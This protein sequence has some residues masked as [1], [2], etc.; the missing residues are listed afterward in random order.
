MS[1]IQKPGFSS[2][3]ENL[4]SISTEEKSLSIPAVEKPLSISAAEKPLSIPAVE[5]PLS[6]PAAEKP[7]SILA[8]EKP[9]SIST[10]AIFSSVPT[11]VYCRVSTLHPHQQDSL[12]NQIRHYQEFM[13]KTQNYILTEIYYDF[14]ISGY[15][16]T[17]PGFC[18]MLEDARKGCF[19]QIITKSITRF[20]RNTDTVLK[21]TRQLKELG[22]DIYF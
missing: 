14:G 8:A 9:L 11:A 2:P 6:I 19:R 10:P 20:A 13:K 22:I 3:Y 21:T 7:L 16:E 1:E 12:E 17:R 18:K 4:L 5:K 15:K